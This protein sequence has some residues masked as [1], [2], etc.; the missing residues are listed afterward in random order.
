MVVLV[1][2]SIKIESHTS[3]HLKT[4]KAAPDEVDIAI[5]EKDDL[6]ATATEEISVALYNEVDDYSMVAA[7]DEAVNEK[8]ES[9]AGLTD[10]SKDIYQEDELIAAVTDGIN[11]AVHNK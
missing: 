2:Y 11:N 3:K 10:R 8:D 4:V 9:M 1:I 5:D 7:A 6:T